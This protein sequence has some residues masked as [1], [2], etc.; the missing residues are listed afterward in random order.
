MASGRAVAPLTLSVTKMP[1]TTTPSHTGRTNPE[2]GSGFFLKISLLAEKAERFAPYLAAIVLTFVLFFGTL[3]GLYRPL[4]FDEL[5]SVSIVKLPHTS[6][7]WSFAKT[8]PDG[9]PPL[10]YYVLHASTD[11]LRNDSLG[12]RMPSTIGYIVFCVCLYVFVSRITSRIYGLAALLLPSITGCWYYLTEGRPYGLLLGCTG[13]AAVSWQSITLNRRR[14]LALSGLA[15]SL[16]G[17]FAVHYF[18]VLI[19]LPF[20]LA[21]FVRSIKRHKID[22]AVWIAFALPSLLLIPYVPVALQMRANSGVATY[23]FARPAWYRSLQDFADQFLGPSVVALLILACVY[24]VYQNSAKVR[25]RYGA[26]ESN[27]ET[28][29]WLPEL[30]LILALT[31]VPVLGIAL[32]K[33]GTHYFYPRYVITAMFGVVALIVLVLWR[34]FSGRKDA[35]LI[36]SLV[37]VGVFAHTVA[38]DLRDI[39]DDRAVPMKKVLLNRIPKVARGDQLPIAVGDPFAFMQLNYYADPA[40]LRRVC[41]LS[42]PEYDLKYRGG[43]AGEYA[44]IR[45]APYFGT[46]VVDYRTWTKHHKDFYLLGGMPFAIAQL[47]EDGAHLE[48]LQGGH[49]GTLGD[50]AALFFRVSF[51]SK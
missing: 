47:I 6:E 10:Y 23:F 21:E 44:L 43:N 50:N 11:L 35:A 12:V 2:I 38:S 39:E 40:L 49:V 20:A 27:L 5:F 4:W 28:R 31:C 33:F 26:S 29:K 46:R 13:L 32:G 14:R 15:L 8:V 9:Q 3:K 25:S 45:S 22:P 7:F 30:P 51:P 19:F 1:Q 41:Y 48:L 36:A 24:S 34:A 37:F 17:A 18:A 16:S 42:S